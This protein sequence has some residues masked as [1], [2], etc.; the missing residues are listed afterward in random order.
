MRSTTTVALITSILTACGGSKSGSSADTDTPGAAAAAAGGAGTYVSVANPE[1]S[2]A[3]KPGGDA[4]I[5]AAG[6]GTSKGTY[7]VEGDKIVATVDGRPYTFMRD[8][9]C[10]QDVQ[11]VFDKSCIG[12]AAGEASNVSTRT[13]PDVTGVW[14]HKSGDGEFTLTFLPGNKVTLAATPPG[15]TTPDLV[16]GTF[17]VEGDI[18]QATVGQSNPLTLQWVNKTYES[19]SF[20]FPMKFVK[21]D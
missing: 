15:G 18:V 1:F 12:G 19:T 10:I 4:V 2:I 8:G 3:F 14:V 7:T 11:H 5:T 13:P 20:G 17:V 21:Q 9:K 16:D 6:I